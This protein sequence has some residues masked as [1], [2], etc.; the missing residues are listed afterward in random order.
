MVM[1]MCLSP[2]VFQ[3]VFQG[4]PLESMNLGEELRFLVEGDAKFV[5]HGGDNLVA[6]A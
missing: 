4:V 2:S 6:E 1:L 3:G 5:L